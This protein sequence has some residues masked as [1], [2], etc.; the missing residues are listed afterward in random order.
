MNNNDHIIIERL[1]LYG[2]HGVFPEENEKGQFFYVSA[3]METDTRKAGKSDDLTASTHYG[4]VSELIKKIVQGHT[5]K[6][7]ETVAEE[8]AESILKTFPYV[9]KVTLS[10]SKPSAP[11]GIPFQDVFIKITRGWNK[12]YVAFGSN[13]GEKEQYINNAMK[14]IKD[15]SLCR[16]LR[17]SKRYE[18]EPYGDVDQDNFLNGVC[19]FETLYYPLELLQYLHELESQAGRKRVIHW[20]PR[21]LDLDILFYENLIMETEALTIPHPDMQNRKFVMQPLSDLTNYFM[22]PVLNKSVREV[23]SQII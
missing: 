6:L 12:V 1:K 21:T 22:H 4:E 16:N 3:D 15:N 17:E 20:G 10:L 5:R 8:C 18:T 9:K 2:Y 14:S 13:M 7:I 19:E 23:L 11:I